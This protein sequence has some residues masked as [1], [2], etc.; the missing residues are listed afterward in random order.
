MTTQQTYLPR[1][2]FGETKATFDTSIQSLCE[3]VSK[4]MSGSWDITAHRGIP[5]RQK[6]S[7][8]R[9]GVVSLTTASATPILIRRDAVPYAILRIP[10]HGVCL[11]QT[12]GRQL[13][14]I[15][16]VTA[17]LLAGAA[18]VADM[19][20]ITSSVHISI[21]PLR[22]WQTT[23]VMLGRADVGTMDA[24]LAESKEIPLAVAGISFDDILRRQLALIDT[25]SAQPAALN[26]L[27]LDDTLYRCFAMLL[28]P[29]LFFPATKNAA[30]QLPDD[31]RLDRVCDYI[32]SR[33]DQP[34]TLTELERL[35][36]LSARGLQYAFLRRFQCTPTAWVR[37]E[38]LELARTRL[39]AAAPGTTVLSIAIACGFGNPGLF[40]RYY[41]K[42]FGELPSET[43]AHAFAA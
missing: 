7:S 19:R 40:A 10:I 43:L 31:R 15:P 13:A 39:A 22:L 18:R 32:L 38:R 6:S 27:G 26:L 12:E 14:E 17:V 42:R 21:D 2:A 34:I 25:L 20:E 3:T 37:Q 41:R 1:L 33:I 28:Q 23:A 24:P 36:G 29:E 11:H 8:V 35:S 30:A 4:V 16:G 9:A 5:F